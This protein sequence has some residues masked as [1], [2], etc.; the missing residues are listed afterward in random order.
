MTTVRLTV[1]GIPVTVPEGASAAAAVATVTDVFRHSVR[2]A[3]RG[4]FCGMGQC[5]EC[6]I[7]ID[8]RVTLACLARATPNAAITTDD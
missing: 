2:G 3:P 8:G 1:N 4:P 7:R 5:F 6:R